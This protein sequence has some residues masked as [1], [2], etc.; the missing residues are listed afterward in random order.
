MLMMIGEDEGD[1]VFFFSFLLFFCLCFFPSLSLH[2]TPLIYKHERSLLRSSSKC[3]ETK[4][5]ERHNTWTSSFL[6]VNNA[7]SLHA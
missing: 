2:E 7:F 1:V 4:S 6:S 5:K 3:L